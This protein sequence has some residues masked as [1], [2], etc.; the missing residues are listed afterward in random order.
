[1]TFM[2]TLGEIRTDLAMET[3]QLVAGAKSSSVPGVES[4]TEEKGAPR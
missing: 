1:M 2:Q 3:H 4:Y